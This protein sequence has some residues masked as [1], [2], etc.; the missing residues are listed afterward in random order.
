M[1]GPD[2]QFEDL[3]RRA[4]Q[5]IEASREL[6]EQL[7]LL[8]D[9][10][11]GAS[12]TPG[13]PTRGRGKAVN[14][15]REWLASKGYRAPEDV[16]SEMAGLASHEDAIMTA[17]VQA[18]RVLAWAGQGAANRVFKVGVGHVEL[19]GPWTPTPDQRMAVFMQLYA[20]MLRAADA[21]MPYGAPK[22]TPDV[23]V[24]NVNKIVIA[25]PAAQPAA[26]A[27][28]RAR[29]MTPGARRIQP[30]LMPHQMQQNQR[31]SG[32]G[33]FRSDGSDRTE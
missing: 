19:P 9:E 4:A 26:P 33:D 22:A 15:M 5:S 1:S 12:L 17:M 2:N 18:E 21:L 13:K 14:Q 30:P 28:D 32:S 31:V 8:P 10:T 7:S 3:A 6:A 29:D 25:Q 23:A 20:I 24:T 11:E 27:A 16:L